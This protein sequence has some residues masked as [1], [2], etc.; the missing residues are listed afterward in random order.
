[1][2]LLLLGANH[3]TADISERELLSFTAES[4]ATTLANLLREAGV[5]EALLISTCNRVE[6]YTVTEDTR[7]AEDAI[8]R[9]IRD[10]KGRDVLS[11]KLGQYRLCG[12]EAVRHLC[13]VASGLD[14]MMLGEKQILGQVKEAVSL[15]RHAGSIGPRLERITSAAARAAKR[16][17]EETGIGAG[18]VSV[19]SAA[20]AL[21]VK[22]VGDL[23]DRRV[24][25]LGAGETGR[26]V[27][28]HFTKRSPAALVI[29]SRSL[30]RAEAAA[31]E[32]RCR[33]ISLTD[34]DRVLREVDV[35]VSAT[36]ASEY[37]ISADTVRR[38]MSAR[39]NRP[40]IIIDIAV[41]RD[42][43]PGAGRLENVFLHDIDALQSFVEKSRDR[44]R[45]EIPRAESII[46]EE[47]DRLMTWFR[48]LSA[49]PVIRQL[50]EHFERI[51][52]HEVAK[53]LKHFPSGERRQVENLTRSLINKLLHSPTTRLKAIES[54]GEAD[55]QRIT[56]VRDLF[57][58]DEAACG[59]DGSDDEE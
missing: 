55:M 37:L 34:A 4:A 36:S 54:G 26:L 41:P 7:S 12:R 13:R 14:S 44:R 9:V 11:D 1:M 21:A 22:V 16:V 52:E 42:V 23:T 43:D 18:A 3:R 48:E 30:S 8:R 45:R 32:F 50:R 27:A 28:K 29:A 51:R 15:A 2:Q 10:S 24:L 19:A 38:L 53:S 57:G 56:A 59:R 17:H 6:F 40:L 25:V 49:V 58:L 39:E 20:V 35:V 33:A 47:T 5:I 31:G 46:D